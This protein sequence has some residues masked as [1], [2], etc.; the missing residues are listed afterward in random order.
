[1]GYVLT[2]DIFGAREAYDMGLVSELVP[3]AEVE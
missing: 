2:G 3:D 1:M